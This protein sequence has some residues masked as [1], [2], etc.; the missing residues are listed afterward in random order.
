MGLGY[1]LIDFAMDRLKQL[2]VKGILGY[3]SIPHITQYMESKG[4]VVYRTAAIR[5]GDRNV[6]SAGFSIVF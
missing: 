2:G 3:S 4:F 1:S 5:L 6:P